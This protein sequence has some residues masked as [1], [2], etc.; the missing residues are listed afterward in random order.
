M[1]TQVDINE[2]R[3]KERDNGGRIFLPY[4]GITLEGILEESNN[5]ENDLCL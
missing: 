5:R 4:G 3:N 1:I 2:G